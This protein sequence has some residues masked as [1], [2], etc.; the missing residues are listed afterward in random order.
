MV[1]V[2]SAV[3]TD[4]D[5]LNLLMSLLQLIFDSLFLMVFYVAV[6]PVFE[7]V[8]VEFGKRWIKWTKHSSVQGLRTFWD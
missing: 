4:R 6:G 3:D 7:D 2:G 5:S 1:E 8:R